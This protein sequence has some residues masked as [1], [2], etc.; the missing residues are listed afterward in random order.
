MIILDIHGEKKRRKLLQVSENNA[1]S[2][3]IFNRHF[4]SLSKGFVFLVPGLFLPWGTCNWIIIQT[5][6]WQSL[7]WK[8]F[9]VWCTIGNSWETDGGQQHVHA[10]IAAYKLTRPFLSHSTFEVLKL[11]TKQKKEKNKLKSNKVN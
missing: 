1:E 5:A 2:W 6:S 4:R 11:K 9:C 7:V 8:L 3:L 10:A